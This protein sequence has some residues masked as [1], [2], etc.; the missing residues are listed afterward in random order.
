[1]WKI[2]NEMAK[3][4]EEKLTAN[5]VGLHEFSTPSL[6]ALYNKHYR[7]PADEDLLLYAEQLT[8]EASPLNEMFKVNYPNSLDNDEFISRLATTE[9][10]SSYL[11]SYFRTVNAHQQAD[12]LD[13]HPDAVSAL[14]VIYE[15]ISQMPS[16]ARPVLQGV[17]SVLAMSRNFDYQVEGQFYNNNPMRYNGRGSKLFGLLQQKMGDA[18][19]LYLAKKTQYLKR[20]VRLREDLF[21]DYDQEIGQP[22]YK[23]WPL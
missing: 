3:S 8:Q 16:V 17:F 13:L 18:S 5:D 2:Q 19:S 6:K 12:S 9:D 4:E 20:A 15:H 21:S 11:L 1:M 23:V 14:A 7:A 22:T 10:L